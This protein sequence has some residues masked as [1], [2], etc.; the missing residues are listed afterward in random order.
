MISRKSVLVFVMLLMALPMTAAEKLPSR[1]QILKTLVKVNDHYLRNHPDP[2]E[3]IPYYS[4][5]KVYEANIWT[6]AVY[7][8]GLMALHSIYPENRYYD[9]AYSWGDGFK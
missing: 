8:E 3:G 9:Y 4:R 5:Q 6:R 2:L 7:F 1:H